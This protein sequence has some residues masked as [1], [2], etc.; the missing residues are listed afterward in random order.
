MTKVTLIPGDGIGKEICASMMEVVKA[1]GV[2]IDWEITL[3]G[4][5]T[6]EKTGTLVHQEVFDS[7][8]RNKIAIKGPLET[9]IGK[10]HRS[11]NV[12]LRKKYDLYACIRPVKSIANISPRFPNV[13][14]VIFRENTEEIGRAHV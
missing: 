3:A 14:L 12:M 5:E 4:I 7:I 11:I 13:D 10:G 2:L 6:F 9:P 8:E 1:T